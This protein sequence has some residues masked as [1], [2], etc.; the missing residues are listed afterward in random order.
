[1]LLQGYSTSQGFPWLL[2]CLF[3]CRPTV[4]FTL[5]ILFLW[6]SWR[7]LVLSRIT[8]GPVSSVFNPSCDCPSFCPVA[9]RRW[10]TA[11][12]WVRSPPCCWCTWTRK[13]PSGR[14]HSCWPI[15]NTACTVRRSAAQKTQHVSSQGVGADDRLLVQRFGFILRGIKTWLPPLFFF[16]FFFKDFLFP[17]SPN[18]SG[19]RHIMIRLSPNSS[20]NWRNIWWGHCYTTVSEQRLRAK[21]RRCCKNSDLWHLMWLAG[22]LLFAD[23][24]SASLCRTESRCLQGSTAPSGSSSVSLTGWET[25]WCSVCL[26]CRLSHE[27]TTCKAEAAHQA[28]LIIKLQL[29]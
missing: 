5:H 21:S 25:C 13:T 16:F 15:R 22:G 12:G 6:D 7:S 10:A 19:F 11:R 26:T 20:P 8:A 18:S 27:S 4:M 29:D 3:C 28:F 1:M 23:C 2:Q 17:G 9:C 14:C 24:L